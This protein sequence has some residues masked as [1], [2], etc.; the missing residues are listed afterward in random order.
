MAGKGIS[1]WALWLIA[2][3]AAATLLSRIN[4]EIGLSSFLS[5]KVR[6]WKDWTQELWGQLFA[7]F[8]AWL[9]LPAPTPGQ[10]DLL[11][12]SVLLL[13]TSLFALLASYVERKLQR[14]P[15]E[16]QE[17]RIDRFYYAGSYLL[18]IALFVIGPTMRGL[19][20]ELAGVGPLELAV[21]L[22][23]VVI[24][25]IAEG[26]ASQLLTS[27]RPISIRIAA[28]LL[29]YSVALFTAFFVNADAAGT[30]SRPAVTSTTLVVAF[31]FAVASVVVARVA[32]AALSR[33]VL[34]ALAVFAT[35]WLFRLWGG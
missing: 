13:G 34:F 9:R 15:R 19:D 24:F 3:P 35:D 21:V 26:Y 33:V 28:A 25:T 32:P 20:R 29:A 23:A 16:A 2:A 22:P 4:D 7:W 17:A 8:D 10:R 18:L 1:R 31:V 6:T 30:F 14:P 27:T 5:E 11:T 12:L